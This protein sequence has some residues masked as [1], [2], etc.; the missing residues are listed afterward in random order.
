MKLHVYI[1]S[2]SLE[3]LVKH[4][5]QPVSNSFALGSAPDSPHSLSLYG[6]T[7]IGEAEL[8]DV[9]VAAVLTPEK[10]V[11]ALRAEALRASAEA[12][13]TQ[14]SYTRRINELLSIPHD[15]KAAQ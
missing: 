6:Y 2:S 15:P 7:Y 8:P 9:T 10:A 14:V 5:Q 13:A 12:H 11:T 4:G 3:A 1:S